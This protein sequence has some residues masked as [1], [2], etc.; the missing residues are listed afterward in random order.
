M[1]FLL[2]FYVEKRVI[3]NTLNKEKY[4]KSGFQYIDFALW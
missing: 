2:L 3:C 1:L 4:Y